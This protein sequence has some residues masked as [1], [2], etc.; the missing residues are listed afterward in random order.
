MLAVLH[1]HLQLVIEQSLQRGAI[2]SMQARIAEKLVEPDFAKYPELRRHSGLVAKLAESFAQFLS[3]T[4]AEIEQARIIALVHDC[5]MRLL[6]FERLYRKS[7]LSSEELAFLREHPSVGAALV[8]PL[9]GGGI[10]RAVLCHHERVDGNGYPNEL[11]GDEI[12][13]LSRVV[14]LCDA[15]VAMTDP[16]T[17]QAAESTDD[18][19]A[20]ITRAAGTQFDQKLAAKFIEMMRR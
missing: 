2:A 20:T 8:E 11:H 17:Y 14:Q 13:L 12:P 19:I 1:A 18:A 16:D 9:L 7:D 10:A 6:D 3:L 5:G 15:W 4:P